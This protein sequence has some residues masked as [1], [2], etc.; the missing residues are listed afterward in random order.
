M[1]GQP[2]SPLF[3]MRF[4]IFW[5]IRIRHSL[6]CVF[7]EFDKS[8]FAT[9]WD[10]FLKNS[11]NQILPLFIV[12][13]W[14]FWPIRIRHSF[15]YG[16]RH[17]LWCVFEYFGQSEF[18]TLD[19]VFLNSSTNQNSP[20]VMIRFWRIQPIII[21]HSLWCV[22][23]EFVPSEFATLHI[24]FVN[25]SANQ[26]SPLLT[27]SFWIKFGQSEFATLY[28]VWLSNFRA[29]KMTLSLIF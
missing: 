23:E 1:F 15:W 17:S 16:I 24:A 8:E 26:N 10:A 2:N 5:P 9:L 3:V 6:W 25:I 27:L 29:F 18:A 4:W 19:N 21:R 11:S 13:F 12:G 14:I 22:F 28:D 7:D 20:L